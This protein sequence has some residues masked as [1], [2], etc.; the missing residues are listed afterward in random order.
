MKGD[1]MDGEEKVYGEKLRENNRRYDSQ[2][3]Q[4]SSNSQYMSKEY[5]QKHNYN[6]ADE[7]D[8]TSEYLKLY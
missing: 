8:T 1:N 4:D 6:K 5:Q 7:K 2:S 3:G